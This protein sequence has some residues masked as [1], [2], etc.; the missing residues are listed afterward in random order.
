M[1]TFYSTN[2]KETF[3]VKSQEMVAHA[4]SMDAT[5]SMLH[6]LY[7]TLIVPVL[8][9]LAIPDVV[10][11]ACRGEVNGSQEAAEIF[12]VYTKSHSDRMFSS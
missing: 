8:Y 4:I 3:L 12:L 11:H 1:I 10:S 9:F 5:T 2:S 7:F 6:W